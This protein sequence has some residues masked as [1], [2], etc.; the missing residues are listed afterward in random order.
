MRFTP[1]NYC[2]ILRVSWN[3]LGIRVLSK[4]RTLIFACEFA[5]L[6]DVG[7]VTINSSFKLIVPCVFRC[8]NY[9]SFVNICH[10][11]SFRRILIRKLGN[12]LI[13]F[14][15]TKFPSTGL[16]LA[17]SKVTWYVD[18]FYPISLINSFLQIS[19]IVP[20]STNIFIFIHCKNKV[21]N[22]NETKSMVKR[23]LLQ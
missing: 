13:S 9:S 23:Q 18:E 14:L 5:L 21:T 3:W 16:N 4:A 22:H 11:P 8:Y 17:I 10:L 1:Q 7:E 19:F 6:F 15:I 20:K 2:I 12:Q